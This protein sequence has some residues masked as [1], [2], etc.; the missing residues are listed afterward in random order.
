MSIASPLEETTQHR[1]VWKRFH[2]SWPDLETKEE[3]QRIKGGDEEKAGRCF[4]LLQTSRENKYSELYELLNKVFTGS[5]IS[6]DNV[7]HSIP[8]VQ[9]LWFRSH[10]PGKYCVPKE[11]RL[12]VEIGTGLVRVLS[13]GHCLQQSL[14]ASLSNTDILKR[15]RLSFSPANQ[16]KFVSNILLKKRSSLHFPQANYEL[17]W[18]FMLLLV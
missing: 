15:S 7:W 8:Y 4:Y 9:D 10:P 17:L 16:H 11:S 6:Q 18:V 12:S 2:K 13:I 5:M 3:R 1:T 14:A